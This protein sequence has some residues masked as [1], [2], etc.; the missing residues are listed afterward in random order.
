MPLDFE[1]QITKFY[2]IREFTG[3]L[4]NTTFL[5]INHETFCLDECYFIR[6]F[7]EVV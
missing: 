3:G 2:A 7:S 1:L 6:V 4:F 5:F